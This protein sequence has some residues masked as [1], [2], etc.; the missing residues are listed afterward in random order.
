M[1]PENLA[2]RS[3]PKLPLRFAW[4]P[5]LPPPKKSLGTNLRRNPGQDLATYTPPGKHSDSFLSTH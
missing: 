3:C 1:F 4:A 5:F 2:V